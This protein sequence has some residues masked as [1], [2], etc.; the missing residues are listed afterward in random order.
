MIYPARTAVRSVK[1]IVNA[2][3]GIP[4]VILANLLLTRRC[5]QNCLQC[6][7][8]QEP[9]NPPFMNMEDFMFL[10]DRFDRHGTQFISL[11]GGEP[12]LHPQIDECIR[13]AAGKQFVH[14][15]LLS[16]LYGS[17]AVV[18]KTI[19]T[20]METG[21]GI[22]V[23]F[24]GFGETADT[25]RGA[26][27]VSDTVQR[28][29]E[30]ITRE[31]KKRRKPIRT[32]ANIVVSRL[33]LHQV[34]EIL[35]YIEELGWKCNVDLYRWTSANTI[36][37]DRM[38]LSND[39]ELAG[40]IERI[41]RSPSVTT[42]RVIID[43]FTGYLEGNIPKRCPY[44][45]SKGFGTK[46]YINP[47]CSVSVC[48][49]EPF[50]NLREQTLTGFFNSDAWKKRINAMKSCTGCWNSC[51]TPSGIVFHPTGLSDI[52]AIWSMVRKG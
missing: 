33:N 19:Q 47:D 50:G 16:T 41:R 49:G 46:I 24:D 18:G 2:T 11:S 45:D 32:S 1:N 39:R 15:Q 28:G 31:N 29:M 51:Y 26:K 21:A 35:S 25:I 3:R 17:D 10:V 43:G 23:S 8:P 52:K 34:P 9:G 38:K 36:E 30:M 4:A 14:V 22:Q 7:I 13:Y 20:L 37:E 44:L 40:A 27:N 48:I 42:P 6:S 5:T 12:I